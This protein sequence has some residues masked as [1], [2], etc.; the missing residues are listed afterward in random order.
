[1]GLK[2]LNRDSMGIAQIM[3]YMS[4]ELIKLQYS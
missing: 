2:E 1:M 4:S 3:A